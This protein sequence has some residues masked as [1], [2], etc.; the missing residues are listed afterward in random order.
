MLSMSQARKRL[1]Q[2]FLLFLLLCGVV[3]VQSEVSQWILRTRAEHLLS[4]VRSLEVNHSTWSDAQTLMTKW[5]PFAAPTGP[6]NA[7]A[8]TYRVE[9]LQV[10]PQSFIGYPDP[11]VHNWLPRIVDHTGLRSV[12]ARGGF[13]VDHGI[14][15]SKWFAEQ[16]AL[17]V[18]AWGQPG[19][20]AVTDL[21]VSSGE[22]LGFPEGTYPNPLHPNRRIRDWKGSYGITVQFMP[23][24]DP[25]QQAALMDFQFSCITR[26]S[27]CLNH[28]EILPAAWSNLQ[29]QEQSPGTR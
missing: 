1:R 27:P 14:V 8:C 25:S 26:F 13:T 29:E 3:W 2:T 11:G 17:P 7:N 10:L 9:F 12:A 22:F 20:A 18:R 23:Q 6:C 15:T 5:K 16:V 21:A 4:D 24:E 19:A 28:G